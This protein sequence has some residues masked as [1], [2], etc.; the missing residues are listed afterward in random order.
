MRAMRRASPR[1][2]SRRAC[3][4]AVALAAALVA[5][6]PAAPRAEQVPLL[7]PAERP[8]GWERPRAPRNLVLLFNVAGLVGNPFDDRRG[9]RV[10]GGVERR[11]SA[12]VSSA[13][14][15]GGGSARVEGYPEEW[16]LGISGQLRWWAL[17]DFERGL[18]LGG[19]LDFRR[20]GVHLMT[21]AGPLVGGRY[22]FPAG[23]VAEMHLG[24][25]LLVDSFRTSDNPN[26]LPLRDAWNAMLP[27]V[28]VGV[29]ASLST[30]RR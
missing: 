24:I 14:V 17:G 2:R 13:V 15:I 19:V 30:G 11:E 26:R 27:G 8:V 5:A 22:T 1:L 18:F 12:R 6:V 29:G 9:F 20:V 23:V 25:P 10:E 3:R 16:A 4:P 28:F 21:G 7:R